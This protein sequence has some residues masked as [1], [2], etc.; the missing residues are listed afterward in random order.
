MSFLETV[1][2]CTIQTLYSLGILDD[3]SKKQKAR[4]E[5]QLVF[6]ERLTENIKRSYDLEYEAK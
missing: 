2:A 1:Q 5:P 6:V 3:S 4:E